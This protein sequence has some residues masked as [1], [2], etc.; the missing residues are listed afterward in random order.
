MGSEYNTKKR[1][2]S[3]K[4]QV[5]MGVFPAFMIK[6]MVNLNGAIPDFARQELKDLAAEEYRE[7]F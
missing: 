2:E 5:D 7:E 1:F 6:D 4:E 3:Y